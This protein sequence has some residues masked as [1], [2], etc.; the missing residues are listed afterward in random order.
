MAQ[1]RRL[2][3][4]LDRKKTERRYEWFILQYDQIYDP[5]CAYHLEIQ[6]M[7]CTAPFIE[8]F[9]K[10]MQRRAEKAGLWMVQVPSDQVPTNVSGQR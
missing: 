8:E 6:W 1:V 4:E 5:T 9:V 7:I 3:I 10:T 2:R